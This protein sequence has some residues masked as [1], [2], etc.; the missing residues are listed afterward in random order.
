MKRSLVNIVA[1]QT[2]WFACV[3][4][5]AN[6]RPWT[7]LLVTGLV[8]G[9]HLALAARPGQEVRLIF[10]TL[11]TGL[12]FD[13]LLVNSGWL[14]YAE[15]NQLAGVAPYWIL[16]L[17]ALFATTLNVSMGWLKNRLVLAVFLGAVFGPLSYLAGQRLGA[18]E[19]V[20]I[21]AG[22]IAL[23]CIWALAMPLLMLAASRFDGIR[24]LETALPLQGLSRS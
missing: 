8:V 21:R 24:R 23:A 5:A 16:A 9:L 15:G 22:I 1:F 20:D 12:V 18:V 7:G 10:L 11:L 19:F 2:G 13:S 6:D 4:G 17:W 14:H 3:L